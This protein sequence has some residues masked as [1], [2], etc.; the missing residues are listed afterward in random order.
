MKKIR[1]IAG[2]LIGLGAW[3]AQAQDK[4]VL[5]LAEYLEQVRTQNLQARSLVQ[6]VAASKLRVDEPVAALMPEAYGEAGWLDNR[7]QTSNPLFMGD[8]TRNQHWRLGVR[9]QTTYGLGMDLYVKSGRTIVEHASPTFLA[10]PDYNEVST[11]LEL[12]QSLWRNGFGE[13]TRSEIEMKRSEVESALL[14]S[15]FQL[16]ELLMGAE[17]TYWALV[18]YNEIVKLQEE[19][20]DRAKKTRDRMSRG[21]K[22][23]LFDDTDAMQAEAAFQT[24]ELELQTSLDE[25]AALVRQFNTFRGS[26]EDSLPNLES[27]PTGGLVERA[28][29]EPKG[30]MRREDFELLKAQA[31]GSVAQA[32]RMRSSIRPQVDLM[33]SVAGTGRDGKTGTSFDQSW[34]DRYPIYSVGI[35]FS[36]YL[37][38]GLVGD[39]KRGYRESGR[40][41]AALQEYA[42]FSEERAWNDLLR[43]QREAHGR[44]KR[45]L[46]VENLQTELVK[47]ER[48]R[49]LNGRTTTFEALNI[50]QGLALSQI[51]RVRAQLAFLQIHNAIKTFEVQP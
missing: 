23:R 37:D 46:S 51:Q 22:L 20:V 26:S 14:Q 6:T 25:R 27:L 18:S 30:K 16:K 32:E 36:T 3:C 42:E 15:Q 33:A 7:Q 9:K 4:G 39:L 48:R 49:L 44:F 5:S 2:L 24:R 11:V 31:K 19:N 47:R 28:L 43:Q 41:A 34:S 50:E 35:V 13:S 45:A 10:V 12:R 29:I 38:F 8:Q 1:M 21:T 17:N 40:A